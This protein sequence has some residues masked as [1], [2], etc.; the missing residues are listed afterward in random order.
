MKTTEQ[1]ALR[2]KED[3]TKYHSYAY[4]YNDVVDMMKEYALQVVDRCV[5]ISKT[6][7]DD[8]GM[9]AELT[10]ELEAI[11]QEII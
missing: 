3:L 11:K 6:Y 5:E 9:V 8:D 1:I 7:I 4:R 2:G 10:K